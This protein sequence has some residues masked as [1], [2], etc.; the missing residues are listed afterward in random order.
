[1]KIQAFVQQHPNIGLTVSIKGKYPLDESPTVFT[2][3][4]LDGVVADE[5][6]HVTANLPTAD[7][8]LARQA[9]ISELNFD[10]KFWWQAELVPVAS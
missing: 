5:V 2:I 9:A 6:W 1:M 7:F 4:R 10:A 8:P 3:K